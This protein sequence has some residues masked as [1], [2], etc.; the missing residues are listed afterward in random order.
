MQQYAVK[1]GSFSQ[2]QRML[3]FTFEQTFGKIITPMI[4]IYFEMGLVCTKV[5]GFV[6]F[7]PVKYFNIFVLSTVTTCCHGDENPN[8]SVVSQTMKLLANCLYGYQ[9]MDRSRHSVTSYVPDENT[10][11]VIKNRKFKI[12]GHI[13]EPFY[14]VERVKSKMKVKKPVIAGFFILQYAQLRMLEL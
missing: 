7:T 13:N 11:V 3:I 14:E 8:Y 10:H 1:E 5:Y 2:P 12:L 4:L 6:E 9:V